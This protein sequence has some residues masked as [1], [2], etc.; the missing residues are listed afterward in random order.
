MAPSDRYIRPTILPEIGT[1]GQQRL[2]KA[3]V[4]VVGLGALGT[5]SAGLLARAG[6]GHLRLVDRDVVEV[7]NL[8][9]Q[10]LFDERDVDLP[11]AEAAAAKLLATNSDIPLEPG[12][13]DGTAP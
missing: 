6:V 3:A 13:Q 11:K 12:P 5:V 10:V 8:Q 2:T 7:N 4:A 1:E 9:R